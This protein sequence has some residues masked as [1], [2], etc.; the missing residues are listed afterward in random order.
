MGFSSS[1]AGARKSL[2]FAALFGTASVVAMAASNV[3]WGGE[4]VAQ[5][6]DIPETVLITGSLIQ[7]AVSVGV[8]VNS[9]R[10]LD[11]VETGQLSV[12]NVLKSVPALDIDAQPSP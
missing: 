7:G 9:L 6:E 3:A 12:T 11:F 5:T 2:R 1:R 10:T 8:P 4:M